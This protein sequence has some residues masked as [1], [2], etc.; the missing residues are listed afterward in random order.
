MFATTNGTLIH[1]EIQDWL[2]TH[3]RF[4]CGLSLDGNKY[5]QDTNRSNSFDMLDL[6]FFL[7]TYP[8]QAVKMTISQETLPFLYEGVVFAHQKGFKVNCNL[9]FGIDWS[10]QNN[11]DI[12]ERELHKLI[13]FYLINKNIEPCSML[14]FPIDHV[15]YTGEKPKVHKWCGTGTDMK[16]YYIDGSS[17]PCQYFMP[18]S[19]GEEKS[20]LAK[21][22]NFEKEFSYDL[23][24]DKC[25]KCKIVEACPTCYG[26]NFVTYG[27]IYKKDDNLCT[28]TK[29]IVKARSYF[30]AKQWLNGDLNISD[31]KELSLL[32]SILIIQKNI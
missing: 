26:S 25:K 22:I 15:C 28:L 11:I 19:A 18:I 24:D 4:I 3:K 10:N 9:A 12:L 7:N 29:I 27:N 14:N 5:M 21:S 20:K 1:N 17:Y 23:L 30:K 13:E 31:E 8:N 32:K 2:K 6:D 16:A